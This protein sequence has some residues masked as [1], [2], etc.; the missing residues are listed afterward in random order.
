LSI[1]VKLIILIYILFI[2]F[3]LCFFF[4]HDLMLLSHSW[5]F[6]LL[7][8]LFTFKSLPFLANYVLWIIDLTDQ[9]SFKLT[10]NRLKL[11]IKLKAR[12]S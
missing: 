3:T 12:L 6:M 4:C 9:K 7:L 5:Q 11:E 2:L 10:D 8:C 1:H